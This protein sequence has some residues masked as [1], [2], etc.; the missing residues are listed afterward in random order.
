VIFGATFSSACSDFT[1]AQSE[2]NKQLELQRTKLL[3]QQSAEL[4]AVRTR[5]QMEKEKEVQALMQQ[6]ETEQKHRQWKMTEERNAAEA[7]LRRKV[8]LETTAVRSCVL[9]ACVSF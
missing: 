8:K 4:K 6:F 5:L 7:E 1:F 2:R 9:L 3:E